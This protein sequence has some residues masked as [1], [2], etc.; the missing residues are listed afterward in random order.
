MSFYN[1]VLAQVEEYL[2]GKC[3]AL[4]SNHSTAK[5]NATLLVFIKS[6]LLGVTFINLPIGAIYF[7]NLVTSVVKREKRNSEG[8]A[9]GLCLYF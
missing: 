3:K 6:C 7:M 9:L 5:K 4:N 8:R 2:P 1:G